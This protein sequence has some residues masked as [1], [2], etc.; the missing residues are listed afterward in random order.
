MSTEV[1]TTT[2]IHPLARHVL[3]PKAIQGR[4]ALLLTALVSVFRLSSSLRGSRPGP[5]S[6]LLLRHPTITLRYLRHY[7]TGCPSPRTRCSLV[8]ELQQRQPLSM[9]LPSSMRVQ[10]CPTSHRPQQRQNLATTSK[11]QILSRKASSLPTPCNRGK[12]L[13]KS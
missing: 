13:R 8:Q 7:A 1:P 10:T 4:K 5:S 11:N 9:F 2:S 6:A 12:I 3:T